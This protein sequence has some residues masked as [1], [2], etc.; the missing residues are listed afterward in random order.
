MPWRPFPNT[1]VDHWVNWGSSERIY[2]VIPV[3]RVSV[4]SCILG[5]LTHSV[6]YLWWLGLHFGVSHP[7]QFTGLIPL[8]LPKV[9]LRFTLFVWLEPVPYS[10]ILVRLNLVHRWWVSGFLFLIMVFF[11]CPSSVRPF[12][13][14]VITLGGDKDSSTE[15]YVIDETPPDGSGIRGKRFLV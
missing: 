7:P 14:P 5:T 15:E 12:Y 8:P 3:L 9:L 2:R 10:M 13:L 6:W 4:V 1:G 11:S